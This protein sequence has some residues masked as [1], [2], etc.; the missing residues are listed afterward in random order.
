MSDYFLRAIPLPRFGPF[1]TGV[2]EGPGLQLLKV[3]RFGRDLRSLDHG[4]G[5]VEIFL[6]D[7]VASPGMPGGDMVV[8]QRLVVRSDVQSRCHYRDGLFVV[9]TFGQVLTPPRKGCE[10][11]LDS[12]RGLRVEADSHE[13]VLQ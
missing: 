6:F 2:N 1:A 10:R 13:V 3:V 7:Q 8:L 12:G 11:V 9:S 5:I 4:N